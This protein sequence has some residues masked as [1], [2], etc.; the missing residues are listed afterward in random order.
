MGLWWLRGCY[1]AAWRDRA[2][3][4][5]LTFFAASTTL[6]VCPNLHDAILVSLLYPTC[7]HIAHINDACDDRLN[8]MISSTFALLQVP[9]QR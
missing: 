5:P 3:T 2:V 6:S 7:S 9:A 4:L 1:A 8:S